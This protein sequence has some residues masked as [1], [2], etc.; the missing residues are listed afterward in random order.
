[1]GGFVQV[2]VPLTI[3]GARSGLSLSAFLSGIRKGNED[4]QIYGFG[5]PG[6]L[7]P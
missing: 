2:E 6:W 1:M 7:Q 3:F 4:K 5:L